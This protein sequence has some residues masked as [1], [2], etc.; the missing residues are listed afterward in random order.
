MKKFDNHRLS[1]Y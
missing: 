1:W